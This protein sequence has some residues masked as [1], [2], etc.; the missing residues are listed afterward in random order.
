MTECVLNNHTD[1][2]HVNDF[3]SCVRNMSYL[4][5]KTFWEH[6]YFVI[7]TNEQFVSIC[8]LPLSFDIV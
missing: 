7:T 5:N 6:I 1:P 2:K 3:M 4:G 8:Q